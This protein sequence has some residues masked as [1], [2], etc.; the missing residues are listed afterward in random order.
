MSHAAG[1]P[2]T[3]PL[4]GA[5]VVVSPS[6]QDRPNLPSAGCPFCV[7]G[8]EAAEPYDVKWIANRWPAM[9]DERCEVILYSSE[10]AASIA[11]LGEQQLC[12]LIALWSER[13]EHHAARADVSYVLIFENRGPEVGATIAHPHGQ[14]YAYRDVPPVVGHELELAENGCI[15]CS[16]P[17]DASVVARDRGW[18]LRAAELPVWPFEL[19]LHPVDHVGD[20]AEAR[21]GWPAL[22]RLLGGAVASLDCHLGREVPYMLWIH[23]R[24]TDG[25]PWQ[26]A[27]L[28]VHIAPL[29]RSPTAL[30][31]VAAAEWGA[32]VFFNPV[33]GEHAASELRQAWP[34]P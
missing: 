26:Q 6:R 16:E 30:R 7:G 21:A 27:H 11:T 4:T 12:S 31:Y 29:Q 2:E 8:L 1:E 34:T 14:L 17:D 33:S 19:V 9:P 10:H 32:G 5:S 23:Q 18:V 28:H 25:Q 24:P 13:T 3:D 22:A 20:L 15:L